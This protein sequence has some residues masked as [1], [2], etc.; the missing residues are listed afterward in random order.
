M[1]SKH[2]A[3]TPKE[4]HILQQYH[5]EWIN[6]RSRYENNWI[7]DLTHAALIYTQSSGLIPWTNIKTIGRVL[8][9][10]KGEE[11]WFSH[12]DLHPLIFPSH[13]IPTTTY[14]IMVFFY[15]L[16]F[17]KRKF[18]GRS[19]NWRFTSSGKEFCEKYVR[20]NRIDSAGRL[21]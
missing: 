1:I 2:F 7:L 13:K 15:H 18:V 4:D 14:G 11:G 21:I 6:L 9:T 12:Q 8:T 19:F 17:L 20:D 16:G 10:I 5:K 3:Q